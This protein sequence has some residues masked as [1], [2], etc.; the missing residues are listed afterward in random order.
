MDGPGYASNIIV[1]DGAFRR[2]LCLIAC[3]TSVWSGYVIE[4]EAGAKLIDTTHVALHH[5]LKGFEFQWHSRQC[6]WGCLYECWAMGERLLMS[7][8]LVRSWPRK[9]KFRNLV[10]ERALGYCH[11]KI[12]ETGAVVTSAKFALSPGNHEQIKQ[13][14]GAFDPS[15][16]Q[17]KQPSVTLL[18]S[19]FKRPVGHLQVKLISEAGLKAI[20]SVVWKFLKSMLALWSRR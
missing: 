11:S 6:R 12:Q 5:S 9:G 20:E 17:L 18:G 3:V 8:Y 16:S 10:G 15:T 4:A 14:D 1:R 19:V 13:G 2:S 7:L